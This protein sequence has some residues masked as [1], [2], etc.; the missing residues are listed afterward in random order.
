MAKLIP[1][2]RRII[3]LTAHGRG[4]KKEKDSGPFVSRPSATK[5]EG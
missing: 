2:V 5:E 1:F 3:E 4:K